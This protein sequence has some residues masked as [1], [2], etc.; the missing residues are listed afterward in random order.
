M[1]YDVSAWALCMCLA[2]R[3][4]RH[5]QCME[6]LSLINDPALT[7]TLWTPDDPTPPGEVTLAIGPTKGEDDG[8][9][10]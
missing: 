1:Q 3:Q 2:C 5:D 7:F 4:S 10:P 8:M 9:V 6:A